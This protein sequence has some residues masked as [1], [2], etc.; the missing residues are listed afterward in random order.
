MQC[1]PPPPPFLDFFPKPC[2]TQLD[3]FPNLCCQERDKKFCRPPKRSILGLIAGF[4][5]VKCDYQAIK[6]GDFIVVLEIWGIGHSKKVFGKDQ[7]MNLKWN[8]NALP[9]FFVPYDQYLLN[10]LFKNIFCVDIISFLMFF[11]LL[12]KQ[13]SGLRYFSS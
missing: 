3:C 10:N 1:T 5:E 13:K 6:C 12:L 8:D 4:S 2:R 7:L 9:L 11:C